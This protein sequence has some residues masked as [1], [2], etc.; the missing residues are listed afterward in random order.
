VNLNGE[1]IG[2]NTAIK[3]AQFGYT[4]IGF[5]IPSNMA[6][7]VADQLRSGGRVR[8]AWLGVNIQNLTP[9]LAKGLG[10]GA[11]TTGALIAQVAPD[12]PAEKAGVQAGDVV[13]AV[14]STPVQ[15]SKDLQRFVLET[16]IGKPL[17]LLVWRKGQQH[18]LGV[19]TAEMPDDAVAARRGEPGAEPGAPSWG[20]ELRNLTPELQQRY[21]LRAR[22][23]AL[24]AQVTPGTPAEEAGLA[25]GDVVVEVDRRPVRSAAEV[26]QALKAPGGAHLLRVQ[27][28][29]AAI[30][31]ML[32]R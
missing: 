22:A 13:T 23:G 4:G 26:G 12:S 16:A 31:V 24:V 18:T 30:F 10:A 7:N 25:A 21:G 27:R 11:P 6:K 28:G 8:R 5:A 2:I 17:H 20:M 14:G 1:V 9:D 3:L 19:T 29:D 15:N 32:K